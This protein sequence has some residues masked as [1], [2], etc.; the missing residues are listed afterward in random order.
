MYAGLTKFKKRINQEYILQQSE[1]M[2]QWQITLCVYMKFMPL[3]TFLVP[4]ITN[5]VH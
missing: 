2:T 5:H 3:N 1:S 4:F